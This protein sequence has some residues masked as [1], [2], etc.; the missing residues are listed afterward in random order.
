MDSFG[1]TKRLASLLDQHGGVDRVISGA[2]LYV[3]ALPSASS[4]ASAFDLARAPP[5]DL[6][7]C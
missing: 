4:T 1:Q 7:H 2:C 6:P 5:L 3:R